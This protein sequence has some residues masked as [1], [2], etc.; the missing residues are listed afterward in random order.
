MA[1]ATYTLEQYNKT[2][3]EKEIETCLEIDKVV[4]PLVHKANYRRASSFFLSKEITP[5]MCDVFSENVEYTFVGRPAYYV[6]SDP[7]SEN[8]PVC[9]VINTKE[10]LLENIFVFDTGA[11]ANNMYG[12]FLENPSQDINVYRIPASTKSVNQMIKRFFSSNR[13]YY[14]SKV[15]TTI[16]NATPDSEIKSYIN[17]LRI[18]FE[19]DSPGFDDRCRTIENVFRNPISLEENLQAVILSFSQSR[20]KEFKKFI[21]SFERNVEIVTYDTFDITPN[22][23]NQAINGLLYTYLERHGYFTDESEKGGCAT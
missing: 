14:L 23:G 7:Q 15:N 2:K 19:D 4:L 12:K 8:Y 17:L 5:V 20:T 22:E 13:N 9:F 16:N 3:F 11:Y 10:N 6:H 18:D 21:S 1:N